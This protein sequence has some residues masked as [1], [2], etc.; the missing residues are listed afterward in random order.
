MNKLKKD[1]YNLRY[2]LIFLLIYIITM[3]LIFNTVCPFRVLFHVNCPGC[4]LTRACISLL[5]GNIIESWH[6]N[7]T[8][9]LWIISIMLFIFDRY[10]KALRIKPFPFVFIFVGIITIVNYYI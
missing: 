4:G 5:K 10:I 2:V 3:N 1:I 8:A 6:Y 7:R 9:I